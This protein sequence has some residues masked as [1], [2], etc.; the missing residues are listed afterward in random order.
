MKTSNKHDCK[1][2]TF[3]EITVY[4]QKTQLTFNVG[5]TFTVIHE[6]LRRKV[7]VEFE[8]MRKYLDFEIIESFRNELCS[9]IAESYSLS[10]IESYCTKLNELCRKLEE[11]CLPQNKII[12]KIS[13][14]NELWSI[15][16]EW[17]NKNQNLKGFLSSCNGEDGVLWS[18]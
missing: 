14:T 9:R 2:E 16:I 18:E 1:S 12:Q 8:P 7:H 5:P 3:E 11:F 10:S 17:L 15:F 4:H 13:Q 6:S